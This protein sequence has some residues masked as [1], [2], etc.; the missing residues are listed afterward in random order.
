MSFGFS[1]LA[2]VVA[3]AIALTSANA[4]AARYVPATTVTY[5]ISAP[6]TGYQ[7]GVTNGATYSY[8]TFAGTLTGTITIDTAALGSQLGSPSDADSPST[9]YQAH[10]GDTPFAT[11]ALTLSGTGVA[12]GALN[13]Q[14]V[15]SSYVLNT[16]D[17]RVEAASSALLGLSY[18]A[19]L[20]SADPFNR[21]IGARSAN[22]QI[23]APGGFALTALGDATLPVFAD[24]A[25]FHLSYSEG[26]LGVSGPV[27]QE[28]ILVLNGDGL[29]GPITP[30]PEPGEW[31]MMIVG[32]GIVG[33]AA[34]RRRAAKA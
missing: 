4:M 29:F 10:L 14:Y 34:R 28:Q 16:Q 30:A 22:L 17:Q 5:T 27:E 8:Q 23:A 20:H 6:V 21:L 11:V 7:Q 32:L 18:G 1:F 31:A 19:S 25:S 9:L 33:G 15:T 3:C 2:R 12:D 24:G 13:P 26:V